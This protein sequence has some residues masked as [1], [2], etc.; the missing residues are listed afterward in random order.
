MGTP[1]IVPPFPCLARISA[2]HLLLPFCSSVIVV[3]GLLT[4]KRA[5]VLGVSSWT[6]VIL[7]CWASALAFSLLTIMGGTMQP[8]SWFWQPAIV[9]ALYLLGQLLTF[10]AVHRGDVSIAAPVMGVKVLMVPA[11]APL[12]VQGESSPRVWMAAALA[13]AGIALVQ[14]RDA[15]IDRSRILA[16]VGFALLAAFSMTVFDLLIQR[17]SKGWGGPGYFLPIS[18]GFAAVLSL[19]FLP[20][21]D[22]PARLKELGV[23][24]PLGIGSLLM[25]I[26][27]IGMTLTLGLFGDATRVNIVY[28]LRGLW[29]VLLT[30]ILAR[31]FA[32][33]DSLPSHRVM[34]Q[35]LAGAVLIGI[36]VLIAVTP[37]D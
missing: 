9:G 14:A 5:Q 17:W 3:F 2:I 20:L 1:P 15:S 37:T 19:V 10:L 22:R 7:V 24:R 33:G 35:R 11:C 30:W 27:A 21:A 32:A 16:S 26:Q 8:V 36:S 23:L 6:S 12:F 18:F 4:L 31:H 34:S 28:S 13:V 25:S 29:G